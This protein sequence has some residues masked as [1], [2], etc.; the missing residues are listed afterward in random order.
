MEL[1][2]VAGTLAVG[3]A[4]GTL[5]GAFGV[6]GAVLTTPGI[7][8]M[9]V[10]PIQAVGSTLPAIIPGSITGALRYHRE[11]LVDRRVAFTCGLTGMALAVLGSKTSD[12]VDAGW[13]MVL[14]AALLLWSGINAI[15]QSRRAAADATAAAADADAAAEGEPTPA[16]VAAGAPSPTTGAVSTAAVAAPATTVAAGGTATAPSSPPFATL[17]ATGAL[18]GFVS[19][20]LGVGGGV[21]MMPMFTS[22]LKLP[23][24]VAVGSSLVAVALFSVPATITHTV[25]GHIDWPIALLLTVGTIPGAQ[26]GSRL[27]IRASDRHVRLALGLF[28]CAIA[29]LYGGRELANVL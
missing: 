1:T 11:G 25:L 6:G 23:V 13:L 15:R 9:G 28:F 7:R 17:V 12:L 14:T 29:V 5:S 24:K 8:A 27:A 10:S 4:A 3:V 20:L 18:A 2:T 16:P 21:V 26:L 19:G 22:V